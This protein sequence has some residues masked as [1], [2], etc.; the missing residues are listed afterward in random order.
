MAQA[1]ERPSNRIRL[2]RDDTA[3]PARVPSYGPESMLEPVTGQST[4]SIGRS[5]SLLVGRTRPASP[6]TSCPFEPLF[7]SSSVWLLLLFS[8]VSIP[9]CWFFRIP[10]S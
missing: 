6:T 4:G 2:R 9:L 1:G 5:I 3:D 8:V 10:L 7:V